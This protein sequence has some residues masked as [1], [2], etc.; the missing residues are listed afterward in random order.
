MMMEHDSHMM[1]RK[2]SHYVG[3]G[4]DMDQRG[5]NGSGSIDVETMLPNKDDNHDD[6]DDDGDRLVVAVAVNEDDDE[7]VFIPS[8][9]EY[10]P[11][12]MKTKVP[13]F[14]NQRFRVYGLLGCT[15]L[16]ILTACSIGVLA[17]LEG[18]KEQYSPPTEAPTCIRCSVDFEEQLELEVGSQK[19]NDPT[20]AEYQAKEWIIYDDPMQLQANDRNFIQRFLLAALYFETHLISDW[21]SC[22]RPSVDVADSGVD[23]VEEEENFE[24]CSFMIVSGI[25]PLSFEG[26]KYLL[27]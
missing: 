18:K 27:Y 20:T 17:I 23:V 6:D 5:S 9:V 15:L 22:N 12:A 16:I 14:K 11:D 24:K 21:R 13:M 10:D 26:S 3:G 2:K 4:D 7:N 25:E 8:A 1:D 19:L